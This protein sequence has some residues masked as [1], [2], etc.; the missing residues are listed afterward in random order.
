[1]IGMR[2][3]EALCKLLMN[4]E[5]K[6]QCLDLRCG[7]LDDGFIDILVGALFQNNNLKIKSLNLKCQEFVTSTGWRTLSAY[8]SRPSCTIEEI[9]L[10][11]NRLG[12]NAATVLGDSLAVNKTLK[13]LD[14][15]SVA[16]LSPRAC[17]GIAKCLRVPTSALLK[18]YL[19][20]FDTDV[21]GA[22]SIFNALSKNSTIKIL[23]M[24]NNN[25]TSSSGWAT[26]FDLLLD[27]RTPLEKLNFSGI[28]IDDEEGAAALA[29][30]I[31][32]NMTTVQSL[33]LN[34]IDS[35]T[36]NGWIA[37]TS[38][39]Q[40]NPSS[41]LKNLA[42]G[43][44]TEPNENDVDGVELTI[45]FAIDLTN[46]TS[47][48]VIDLH[49]TSIPTTGWIALAN[50]LCDQTSIT[51][52][53]YNSNHKLQRLECSPQNPP[54]IELLLAMNKK[55]RKEDVVRVKILLFHL[56]NIDNVAHA[57]GSMNTVVL[58]SAI[59]WIGRDRQGFLTMFYLF[60]CMPWLL[61]TSINHDAYASGTY[62]PPQKLRKV[63]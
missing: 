13:C 23:S 27:A 46:N 2:G 40:P 3:C 16:L 61:N 28:N 51:S 36:A 21:E 48:E 42:L 20:D 24:A 30:L 53:C 10:G 50:A 22:V 62:E 25:Q 15:C 59:E 37:F 63:K 52:I 29:D 11:G 7:K 19:D 35:L 54:E 17:R 33:E 44:V 34:D 49:V 26:C 38:V 39:V 18:L 32:K 6:I 14:L 56:S 4:S 60:R 47:L 5:C 8:L 1:M 12:D 31:A 9:Y 55:K 58:P 43:T 41:K 45:R 57:F